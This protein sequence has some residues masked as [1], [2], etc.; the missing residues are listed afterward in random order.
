MHGLTDGCIGLFSAGGQLIR[1]V[2]TSRL[3]QYLSHLREA[4][5]AYYHQLVKSRF[6]NN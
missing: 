4:R 1:N 5:V 6:F 3:S 2:R